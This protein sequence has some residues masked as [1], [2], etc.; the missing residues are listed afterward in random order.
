MPC[1]FIASICNAH[2]MH[3][4]EKQIKGCY[5]QF[6]AVIPEAYKRSGVAFRL[7]SKLNGWL[8]A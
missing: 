2:A 5:V 1:N 8:G 7:H 6:F 3:K 4:I